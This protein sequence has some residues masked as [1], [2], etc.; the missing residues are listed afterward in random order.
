M[1]PKVP[2]KASY[3]TPIFY[4]S[5]TIAA[6]CF[7]ALYRWHFRQLRKWVRQHGR[8]IHSYSRRMSVADSELQ[9]SELF[10]QENLARCDNHLWFL[11]RGV[12]P[13]HRNGSCFSHRNWR[14]CITN[15]QTIAVFRNGTQLQRCSL[16]IRVHLYSTEKLG[17]VGGFSAVSEKISRKA[18]RVD[19]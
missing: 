19:I 17:N 3:P 15:Q 8:Q 4:Y 11:C 2:D 5:F 18:A 14:H 12:P 13:L 7:T 1:V 10:P 6:R 9:Q 16:H